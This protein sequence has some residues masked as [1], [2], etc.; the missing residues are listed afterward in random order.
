MK[1]ANPIEP[2]VPIQDIVRKVRHLQIRARK[3][4]NDQM[5]SDYHSVFKGQGIEFNDV[6]QY[7]PGDDIRN[8]DWK[9][10]ARMNQTF[11]RTYI[12]ER[13]LNIIFALD[14][15]ASSHFG[16]DRTKRDVM[17][18]IV[19]LLGFASFFN[20]DRAGL[21]LFSEEIEKI[22]PPTR[23]QSQLLRLIRDAWY[24]PM[25][26]R[27]TN[28]QNA[29][30]KMNN[31]LKKRSVIFLISDF[32]DEGYK[33]GLGTLSRKHDVIPIVVHDH[34]ES[35]LELT[36]KSKLPVLLDLQ[37]MED[38]SIQALELS[39]NRLSNLEKY[40]EYYRRLFKSMGLDFLEVDDRTEYMK[41]LEVLL[42]QRMRRK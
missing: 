10:S 9:V 1:P 2:E 20:N 34:L 6:R 33:S 25:S 12:E 37:D 3:L 15:S 21:I 39:G 31:L 7:F 13:Q 41:R 35:S 26:K 42:R 23:N 14:V 5:Q 22:L 29:L 8:I 27:G 36:I 30:A 19:G 32:L 24:Y 11:T 4:V 28:I 38:D 17:A 16:S 40:Q 18:E